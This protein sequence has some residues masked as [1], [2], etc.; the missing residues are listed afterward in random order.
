MF[1]NWFSR[2]EKKKKATINPKNTDDKCFQYATTISL[3][4]EEIKWNTDGVW[5][6]EPLVNKYNSKGINYPS[7]MDNWQTFEKN[8]PIIGLNILYIKK[9]EISPPYISK[10]NSSCEK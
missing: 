2:L 6:F 1:I 9:K 5:N 4:Y 7:K 10:I 3:K 8:N